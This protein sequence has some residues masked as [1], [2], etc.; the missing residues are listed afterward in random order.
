MDDK[1]SLVPTTPVAEDATE[2]SRGLTA[3]VD[4]QLAATA[5][6]AT[7]PPGQPMGA[8]IL[9]ALRSLLV[10]GLAVLTA[11][12]I[13][14]VVIFISSIVSPPPPTS[15]LHNISPFELVL[16]AY[17]GLWDGAF[18]SFNNISDTVVAATPYIFG[19]LAVALGFRTGLFNIG[20]E[21]QIAL[22]SLAAA[23]VG[24]SPA[25]A[26]LSPLIHVPLALLAGCLAGAIWGGIPG[27]LKAQTGAHEVIT[28]I[29]LNYIAIQIVSVVVNAVKP[30]GGTVRTPAIAADAHLL[31]LVQ[32]GSGH[33][34]IHLGTVLAILAAAAVYWLLWRTVSGFELR[35]VG[36]NAN[37]ARYAG[38]SV[39]RSIVLAMALSGLLG[40]LAG[41]VEVTGVNFYHSQGFSKG[42]GF[43]AIS[44]ALLGKSSPA[45]VVAAAF[46]L[47]ALKSGASGMQFAAGTPIDV[48]SIIQGLILLFV[49]ADEIVRYIY[50]VRSRG[51]EKVVLTRGWGG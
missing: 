12:L 40:G 16:R 4:N 18:G 20:V 41:A 2:P 8:R 3:G 17:G 5:T 49:A 51:E 26:S 39:K 36:A 25:L 43:D 48:I 1:P 22:G 34:P 23:A 38:I 44:V 29:M 32:V 11:L 27:L 50:R 45:G 21:G 15:P 35:T 28:T 33:H 14:A 37:A 10:P 24:F 7:M 47:G 6:A 46:L 42:Y 9:T 31:P 13:G 30:G 19:G